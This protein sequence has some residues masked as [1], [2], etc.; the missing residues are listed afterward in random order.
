MRKKINSFNEDLKDNDFSQEDQIIITRVLKSE[1]Y[2][3]CKTILLYYPMW[4][5]VNTIPLINQSIQDNKKVCLPK[6]INKKMYFIEISKDWSNDLSMNTY[7]I[8]EPN[9]NNYL[10]KFSECLMIVPNLGLAKDKTRIGHGKGYY[11]I[12]LK[13]NKNIFKMGICRKHVLF[14]SLPTEED[15]VML[16]IVISSI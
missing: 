5:E 4:N 1:Q 15:D 16:D 7:K 2:R 10:T 9:K 3:N 13:D 6:I 14:D 8:L 12:F 11:D